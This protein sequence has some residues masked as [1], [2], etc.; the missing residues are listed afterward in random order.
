M[1]PMQRLG[2]NWIGNHPVPEEEANKAFH[3]FFFLLHP[4]FYLTH[5][6]I[7]PLVSLMIQISMLIQLTLLGY[8]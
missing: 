1:P 6:S 5:S 4:M 8:A 2:L 7:P 3:S